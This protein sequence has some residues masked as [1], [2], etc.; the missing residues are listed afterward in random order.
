MMELEDWSHPYRDKLAPCHSA[1]GLARS[2]Q[3]R[4]KVLTLADQHLDPTS[5]EHSQLHRIETT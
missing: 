5:L 1:C 2:G 4:E 3:G